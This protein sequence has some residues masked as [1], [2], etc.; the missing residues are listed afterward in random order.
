MPY[1]LCPAETHNWILAG[2]G[3][4]ITLFS[5]DKD[6][7][8]NELC[9]VQADFA[10]EDSSLNKVIFAPKDLLAVSGG[11]DGIARVFDISQDG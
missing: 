1:D 6:G 11:E 2:L 9:R 4:F 8:L 10:P 3:K 7:K 5:I